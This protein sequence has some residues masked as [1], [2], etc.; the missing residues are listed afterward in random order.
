MGEPCEKALMLN[1]I[2]RKNA[3]VLGRTDVFML[4]LLSVIS[5]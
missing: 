4:S 1:K 3:T 2:N 5:C